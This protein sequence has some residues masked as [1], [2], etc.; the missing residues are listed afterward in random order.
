[1][2]KSD[3][4][5]GLYH[6]KIYD[7]KLKKPN[8]KYFIIIPLILLVCYYFLYLKSNLNFD[9]A[10]TDLKKEQENE[11]QEN[12]DIKTYTETKTK[13]MTHVTTD[14]TYKIEKKH[15]VWLCKRVNNIYEGIKQHLTYVL[16][17]RF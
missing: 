11:I 1:M 9:S 4:D 10:I 7:H 16:L 8:Y 17:K 3:K 14:S 12:V 5:Y 15:T 6:I 2:K 13:D